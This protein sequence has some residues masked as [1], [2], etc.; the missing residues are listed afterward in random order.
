LACARLLTATWPRCSL[1]VPYSCMWRCAA[2]ANHWTATRLA[3]G[4]SNSVVACIT[5]SATDWP[6]ET[7][8]PE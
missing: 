4:R 3:Y 8:S 6:V 1:V 7:R 2:W 5:G